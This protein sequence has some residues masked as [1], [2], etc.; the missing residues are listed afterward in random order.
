MKS[1]GSRVLPVWSK[2]KFRKVFKDELKEILRRRKGDYRGEGCETLDSVEDNQICEYPNVTT[3]HNL[4]GLALSG[5]GIRSAAFC[6]GALDRLQEANKLKDFDYMSAVSG[7]GFI[8]GLLCSL[9]GEKMERG[10]G[11]EYIFPFSKSVGENDSEELRHLR[12]RANYLTPGGTSDRLF[13]IFELIRKFIVNLLVLLPSIFFVAFL[14]SFLTHFNSLDEVKNS[15]VV[16]LMKMTHKISIITASILI[17]VIL[18]NKVSRNYFGER[19]G[20]QSYQKIVMVIVVFMLIIFS[21]E[22]LAYACSQFVSPVEVENKRAF[23]LVN[24]FVLLLNVGILSFTGKNYGGVTKKSDYVFLVLTIVVV[25][26]FFILSAYV[27]LVILDIYTLYKNYWLAMAVVCL[28]LL[29]TSLIFLFGLDAN[30]TSLHRFYRNRISGAF[31]GVDSR[32]DKL[33]EKKLLSSLAGK[34]GPLLILNAA[35]N[36]H[37]SDTDLSIRA[38]G[39]YSMTPLYCGSDLCDY[40]ETS[41]LEKHQKRFY[42]ASCMAI[43]GAAA[44]PNMGQETR[45]YFPL[46]FT[47]F[48]IRLGF[49]LKNSARFLAHAP[50]YLTY[51]EM[52]SHLKE[53]GDHVYL[54]DGGHWDNLG[55]YELLKRRCKRIIAIDSGLDPSQDLGSLGLLEKNAFQDL[56]VKISFSKTALAEF[57][58]CGY[59]EGAIQYGGERGTI[60]YIQSRYFEDLNSL[61]LS[62]YSRQTSDFPNENTTNQ[63]FGEKQFEAYRLLGY[64]VLNK[65]FESEQFNSLVS[66]YKS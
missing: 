15:S 40:I 8:A 42:L 59:L 9:Q 43:S 4:W 21:V 2:V 52:A 34:T 17:L 44:S 3:D 13:L 65:C 57:S 39:P 6:L 7:G 53:T 66:A 26:S 61:Y 20:Q 46:L 56:G 29:A 32:T 38:G 18:C 49:W 60:V 10:D 58:K 14:V 48:N 35:L 55:V 51:F 62:S 47:I 30:N 63:F 27:S 45:Q 5:G 23:H 11:A 19:L 28:T 16:E 1:I 31:L 64:S 33:V 50:G 25:F 24:V 12:E 41:V 22:Y 36:T 37:R 54:S